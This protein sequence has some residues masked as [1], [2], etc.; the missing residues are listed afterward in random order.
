MQIYYLTNSPLS[1]KAR[2]LVQFDVDSIRQAAAGRHA[3]PPTVYVADPDLYE[4]NGRLLRDSAS[5]RLLGYSPAD[6]VLY[7]NDGCNSCTHQLS[8]NLQSIDLKQRR[9]FALA[10]RIPEQLLDKIAELAA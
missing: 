3:P 10:N 1:P 8:A 5:P 6:Q 2:D 4:K 7:A 9:A